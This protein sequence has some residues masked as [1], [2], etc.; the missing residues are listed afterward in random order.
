MILVET[1]YI[2]YFRVENCLQEKHLEII[3]LTCACVTGGKKCKF[4]GKFCV[5]TKWMVP[6]SKHNPQVFYSRNVV[7]DR[8]FVMGYPARGDSNL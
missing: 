4:F 8:Y 2:L 7:F 6:Y 3:L 5:R 1:K